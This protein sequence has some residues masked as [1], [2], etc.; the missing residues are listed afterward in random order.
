MISNKTTSRVTTPADTVSLARIPIPKYACDFLGKEG[1]PDGKYN[2][3]HR[4]WITATPGEPPMLCQLEII[5]KGV[6]ENTNENESINLK[7]M[8][9]ES[10]NFK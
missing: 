4:P 5:N 8:N 1:L 7:N 2:Y 10:P 6:I 3:H 9:I